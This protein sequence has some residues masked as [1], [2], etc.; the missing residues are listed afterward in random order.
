MPDFWIEEDKAKRKVLKNKVKNF[1]EDIAE[2][3]SKIH[4]LSELYF[5][6]E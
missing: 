3:A 4:N 6:N 1:C 5:K 2:K